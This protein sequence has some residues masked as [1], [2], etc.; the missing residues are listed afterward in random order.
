MPGCAPRLFQ[1]FFSFSHSLFREP[2]SPWDRAEL[3]ES[4]PP[5][6]P[7]GLVRPRRWPRRS[8]TGSRASAVLRSLLS[9]MPA[10]LMIT[11]GFWDI[12]L[13]RLVDVGRPMERYHGTV[14]WLRPTGNGTA[15]ARSS[16]HTRLSIIVFPT[17]WIFSYLLQYSRS[18]PIESPCERMIFGQNYVNDW[19]AGAA[20]WF[21]GS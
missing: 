15:R 10:A 9:E 13:L 7:P 16:W 21:Y 8:H 2:G 11:G 5:G 19:K 18:A 17:K 6:V 20:G 12:C 1:S 4:D 14:R 3:G